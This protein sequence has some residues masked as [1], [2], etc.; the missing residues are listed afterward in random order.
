MWQ[1]IFEDR[2]GR[3]VIRAET[4]D[5]C[6][7][8]Y[9]AQVPQCNPPYKMFVSP[10]A[11]GTK[12]TPEPVV[13]ETPE[14]EGEVLVETTPESAAGIEAVTETPVVEETPEPEAETA[15]PEAAEPAAEAAEEPAPAEAVET[16]AAE[17]PVVETPAEEPAAVIE[18]ELPT[19]EPIVAPAEPAPVADVFGDPIVAKGNGEENEAVPA[20]AD[21]TETELAAEETK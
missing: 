18:P 8:L 5:K 9:E 20:P 1:T 4:L 19:E 11:P 12:A 16:P 6:V 14:P 10:A 17:E 3:R 7:G 2:G 13:D 15:E 21:G